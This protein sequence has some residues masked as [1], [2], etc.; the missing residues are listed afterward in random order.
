[1]ELVRGTKVTELSDA[2]HY[3][4]RQR[5]EMFVQVCMRPARAPEGHHS[6]DIKPSNIL[7]TSA[8]VCQFQ[9]D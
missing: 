1:M 8:M 7:V 9:S 3:D 5:L 4:M 6:S 2:N